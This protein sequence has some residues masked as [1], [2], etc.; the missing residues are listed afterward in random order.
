MH[1]ISRRASEFQS[2]PLTRGETRVQAVVQFIRKISIHSPHTRGDC[3]DS[4]SATTIKI[5]IHSP[6]TRGDFFRY[7]DH[8]EPQPISIHSPHTRGDCLVFAITYCQVAI[9]IHSPHTRGDAGWQ[10]GLMHRSYFNPLPSYEGRRKGLHP[11]S[12]SM[13]ISIHS[14]HTRGDAPRAVDV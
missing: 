7:R 12:V 2:T 9:S 3:A 11:S 14:P 6:H 1:E 10:S 4:A 5:S 13:E 8:I